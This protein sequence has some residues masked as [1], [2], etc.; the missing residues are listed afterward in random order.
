MPIISP[1]TND[2]VISFTTGIS[3]TLARDASSGTA[4]LSTGGSAPF[5]IRSR[6]V[7]S[8]RG[9]QYVVS[10]TF[11]Q[12]STSDISGA[13]ASANLNIYGVHGTTANFFV[14]QSTQT[15][16]LISAD[17]D[18]ITGWDHDADNSSNVTYYS[19]EVTSWSTSGYNTIPLN[20]T[21]LKN[22]GTL[23][24][25]KMCLIEADYDLT[26]TEPSTGTD[27]FS[28]V[29]FAEHVNSYERPYLEYTPVNATFFGANF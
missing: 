17:F 15:S 16:P 4:I 29:Y 21:A 27:V 14:V 25:L 28:G 9:T 1:S 24:T 12:F 10:R 8:G 22:M 20:A 26:D 23:S 7:S 2:G 3:W 13:P 18:A 6:K 19:S 5:G 11:M